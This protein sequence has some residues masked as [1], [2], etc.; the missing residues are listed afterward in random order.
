MHDSK[1]DSR[2][3]ILDSQV[4]CHWSLDAQMH[5]PKYMIPRDPKSVIQV[6]VC[7]V[8]GIHDVHCMPDMQATA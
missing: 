5:D 2:P 8:K 3:Q 6:M 1:P 7:R 4:G